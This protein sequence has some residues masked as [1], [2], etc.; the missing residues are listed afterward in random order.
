MVSAADVGVPES[1]YATIGVPDHGIDVAGEQDDQIL[2]FYNRSPSTFGADRYLLTNPAG[3]EGSFVGADMI[4]QVHTQKFFF[5][6]GLTA[7]RAEGIAANRGF[8]PLEND[9]GVIGEA[10]IDPNA[11]G[12]AQGRTFTERGY[13]IKTAATYAFPHDTTFGIIGRYQDGQHFARLV[14]LPGL[15]QG[16]EAV[17]AFRNGRTRFTFEMTVDARLQK[18]FTFRGRRADFIVDAYNLFNEYLEVEEITVSGPT[19]R[20]KS[21]SQPPRALHFGVRIPF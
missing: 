20:Q 7:G 10:Y 11:L 9:N 18:G 4:G 8:G 17:R 12:H 19:S 3:D 15:N 14:I 13:T 5:F 2:I 6:L 21:A 16:A 1:T